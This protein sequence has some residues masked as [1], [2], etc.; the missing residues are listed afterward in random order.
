MKTS[1][2][3]FSRTGHHRAEAAPGADQLAVPPTRKF[4]PDYFTMFLNQLPKEK[5]KLP[6]RHA[7]EVRGSGFDPP[8]FYDLLTKHGVTVVY[9]EDDQFP[10]CVTLAATLRWRA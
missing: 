10:N 8:A 6:L 3:A 7:L 4:D 5:D 2:D 9:A 1:I